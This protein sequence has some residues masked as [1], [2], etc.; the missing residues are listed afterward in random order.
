[1]RRLPFDYAARNLG[2]SPLRLS[3]S[4]VGSVLVVVLAISAY[5]FVRGM[6]R[7]LVGSGSPNNVILLGAGSEESI[8]RSEISTSVAS[9]VQATI[10]GLKSQ[11]GQAY[12]SPEVHAALAVSIEKDAEPIGQAVFRGVTPAAFSVHPQVRMIE[13][14]TPQ[15]GADELLVG[16]LASARLGLSGDRLA[17]GQQLWID[18]RPF[19]IVGRFAAPNTVMNA[20]VWV[21]LTSIQTLTRREGISC[22]VL[23]LGDA[24]FADVDLF[25]KSRVD[26][27]LAAIMETE[28]YDQLSAFYQPVKMMVW[29]TAL[30][31]G[32]GGLLGGLN[33]MY[34]AF[35]SRIREV[36]TLQSLGYSRRAIVISFLQ[37]SLL[38]AATGAVLGSLISLA[39]LDGISIRFSMGAFGLLVDAPTIGFGIAIGLLLG[40]IGSIPPAL[41]CLRLPIAEAL[42]AN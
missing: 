32:A 11:A 23:T 19:T 26:L 13:G 18:D 41:R 40:V 15:T 14:R 27:E 10:P 36:G 5:A 12:V 22:V 24:E 4:V 37:E 25:V 7:S 28:Y 6:D 29:I 20:E 33:T 38:A 34:A 1:M 30:L 17:V 31:I 2:R 39:L 9:Q 8:E 3:I 21:P 35:A 42:K 16:Q